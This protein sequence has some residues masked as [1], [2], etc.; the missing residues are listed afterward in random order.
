MPLPASRR[1]W[2]PC[3]PP[4]SAQYRRNALKCNRSRVS[5]THLSLGGT[6]SR[7]SF[8]FSPGVVAFLLAAGVLYARAVW[9]L[10]GRGWR[11]PRLQQL[12]W[13]LG[14]GLQA[15]ALVGPPD[16][17]ADQLLSWHMAQHL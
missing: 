5:R 7:V 2:Q 4:Y 3:Q 6:I 13:W 17:E 8:S 11:V 1:R 10:R 9:I 15:I 14:L 12:W 16:A